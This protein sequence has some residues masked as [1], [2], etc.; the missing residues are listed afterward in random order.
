L[1]GFKVETPAE[2]SIGTL[3]GV[4]IDPT[5]AR[6]RYF[7]V[8]T[9]RWL[10]GQ[11]YLIPTECPVSVEPERNILRVDVEASDIARLDDCEEFTIEPMSDEDMVDAMFSPHRRVA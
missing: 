5:E 10:R 8:D 2:K 7:V 4:L 3:S 9:R 11:T 6:V 1:A